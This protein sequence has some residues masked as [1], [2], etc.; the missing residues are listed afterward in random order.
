MS[1]CKWKRILWVT[2]SVSSHWVLQPR[3]QGWNCQYWS[4]DHW[5]LLARIFQSQQ[6]PNSNL[7]WKSSQKQVLLSESFSSTHSSSCSHNE[8][9]KTDISMW[10]CQGSTQEKDMSVHKRCQASSTWCYR[11]NSKWRWW[12]KWDIWYHKADISWVR[13]CCWCQRR[14]HH[15]SLLCRCW[16]VWDTKSM[17]LWY[18]RHYSWLIKLHTYNNIYCIAYM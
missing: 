12:H 6:V 10:N 13:D 18:R 17:D 15:H 2:E 5:Q 3:K 11:W 8:L 16:A 1:H 7:E 9:H 14:I 4:E